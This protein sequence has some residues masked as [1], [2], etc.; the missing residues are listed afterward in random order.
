MSRVD[1]LITCALA[2]SIEAI[3][4]AR[5]G[6]MA[7]NGGL[8]TRSNPS[9]AASATNQ[10]ASKVQ[11]AAASVGSTAFKFGNGLPSMTIAPTTV[12]RKT[13]PHN[14]AHVGLM[15]MPKPNVVIV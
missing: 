1:P 15:T 9:L 4:N 10:V 3:V 8:M 7:T 12:P 5:P 11:T 6:S 2:S 14:D 13:Y